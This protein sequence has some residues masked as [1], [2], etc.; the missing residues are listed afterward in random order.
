MALIS[1]RQPDCYLVDF[2][3]A[4]LCCSLS[5]RSLVVGGIRAVAWDIPVCLFS[6]QHGSKAPTQ[7]Q[8]W[9]QHLCNTSG[10]GTN[11]PRLNQIGAPGTWAGGRDREAISA[12][13]AVFDPLLSVTKNT[14]N[15]WPPDMRGTMPMRHFGRCDIGTSP[16]T[17]VQQEGGSSSL[18]HQQGALSGCLSWE[19]QGKRAFWSLQV[20]HLKS[21]PSLSGENSAGCGW[22][23]ESRPVRTVLPS[24]LNIFC[25][26]MKICNCF[27][28]SKS[29]LIHRLHEMWCGNTQH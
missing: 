7:G 21:D 1:P 26:H 16:N 6:W 10:A 19:R 18:N 14:L 27:S 25:D 2:Y 29:F 23:A 22:R 17:L 13:R 4:L 12:L 8:G 11:S 3:C 15:M 28:P 20:K 24:V 5:P 9:R